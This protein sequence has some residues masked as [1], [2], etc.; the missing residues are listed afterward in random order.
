MNDFFRQQLTAYAGYHR[1]ERNR[2]THIF[3]IPIIFL[4]VVLPLSLWRLSLFGIPLNAAIVLAIPAVAAWILLDAGVGLALLVGI[5]PFLVIAA[6]GRGTCQ[7]HGRV[8]SLRQPVHY[9][10]DV[11][12]PR[13]CPVRA[14]QAG[15][16]RQSNSPADRSDVFGRE[17]IG[18]LGLPAR[19]GPRHPSRTEVEASYLRIFGTLTCKSGN[20]VYRQTTTLRSFPRK[21]E[22][23][24]WVPAFAG[25]NG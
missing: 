18:R 20:K 16:A 1:D 12:D 24:T 9:R 5:I 19:S 23:R 4:A 3:G 22:S 14:S 8:A 6:Y 10:L 21:R 7:S 15:A 11:A 13:A 2:V 25:T 17:I